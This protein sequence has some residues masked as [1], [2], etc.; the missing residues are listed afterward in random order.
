MELE[1]RAPELKPEFQ[2]STPVDTRK[3]YVSP[4]GS[5]TGALLQLRPSHWTCRS[6][7]QEG[8]SGIPSLLDVM[9]SEYKAQ[10][11]IHRY[12]DD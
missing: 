10:G 2:T 3:K 7:L 12:I 4:T 1:I 11:G 6:T 8:T 9:G 5:P